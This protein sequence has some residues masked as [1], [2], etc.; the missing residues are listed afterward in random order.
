MAV[1][2]GG[3]PTGGS[4]RAPRAFLYG[5]LPG[6]KVDYRRLAGDLWKNSI[7]SASIHWI[8]RNLPQAPPCVYLA[9]PDGKKK[10]VYTH[11]LTKLLTRPNK[12]Y[13]GRTL[14]KATMLS[15]IVS[16][17]AYWYIVRGMDGL[18]KEL[19]YLPHYQVRP[20]PGPDTDNWIIDYTYTQNGQETTLKFED[21]IH[22]RDGLNPEAMWL[23]L[24]PLASAFR[25]IVTDNEAAGYAAA[26]LKNMG[27]P[28][29]IITPKE[30]KQTFDQ[31]EMD[32][33]KDEYEEATQGDNRGRPM[34]LTGPID[35]KQMALS[36]EQLL[37]DTAQDK[38]EERICALIGIPPG[39]L[40]LGV[41]IKKSTYSNRDA[42][43]AAA[44]T[45]CI[46]PMLDIIHSDLDVQLLPFFGN[47]AS[48]TVGADY[49][50]VRALQ[51][52]TDS[53]YQRL[54]DAT[55]GPFITPNEARAQISLKPVEDGDKLYPPKAGGRQ[56]E[57]N[58][59]ADVAAEEADPADPEEDAG[60]GSGKGSGKKKKAVY[61]DDPDE[62]DLSWADR[63]LAE[64]GGIESRDD[65][66]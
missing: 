25:E 65:E 30:G 44:W 38:P 29:C 2:K 64:I 35:V 19:W 47:P 28:G 11:P 58:T 10:I 50:Q 40:Q 61:G 3:L 5:L 48:E 15:L 39:V 16:G 41:G 17:N 26:I 45:M 56:P 66:G 21:V 54:A 36:P 59:P 7:V 32:A 6:A 49:S 46:I 63:V 51:D 23:G 52:S 60:A 14:R 22:F 37:M 12:F 33:L 53:L 18:P 8:G 24:S 27:V 43:T 42:D 13:S 31:P 34:V 57:P 4:G 1:L 55:G 62:G 20:N 9:G